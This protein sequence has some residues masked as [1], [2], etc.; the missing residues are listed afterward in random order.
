MGAKLQAMIS[1]TLVLFV[2]DL[3][4]IGHMIADNLGKFKSVIWLSIKLS[5]PVQRDDNH[6]EA[7]GIETKDPEEN[8]NFA[9]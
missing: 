3:W 7:R 9:S 6:D 5:R 1:I 2:L 8:H 4:E